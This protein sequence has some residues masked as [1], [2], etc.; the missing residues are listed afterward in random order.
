MRQGLLGGGLNRK[1]QDG[2]GGD[3]CA[4]NLEQSGHSG[5]DQLAVHCQRSCLHVTQP[6]QV[7]SACIEL[8]AKVGQ[9]GGQQRGSVQLAGW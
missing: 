8:M 1:Q 7:T 5:L 4:S 6:N 3:D 9:V 2:V